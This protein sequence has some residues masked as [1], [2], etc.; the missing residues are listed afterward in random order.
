L[1]GTAHCLLLVA[2]VALMAC[3]T[4]WR[5]RWD[6]QRAGFHPDLEGAGPHVSASVAHGI[7]TDR[8]RH[9]RP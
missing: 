3:L 4:C 2:M 6:P 5:L 7:A 8:R 9:E 1:L